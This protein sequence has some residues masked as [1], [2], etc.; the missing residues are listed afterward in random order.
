MP[1]KYISSMPFLLNPQWTIEGYAFMV[2]GDAVPP[3]MRR[4][5]RLPDGALLVAATDTQGTANVRP[6]PLR[7]QNDDGSPFAFVEET[8]DVS[9]YVELVS[10][11][12]SLD[13]PDDAPVW[14]RFHLAHTH[15]QT[16]LCDD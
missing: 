11:R 1:S 16:H 14:C 9:I 10:F 4:I 7:Y 2:D 5:G 3:D 8:G 15:A 13:Q 12:T 6:W